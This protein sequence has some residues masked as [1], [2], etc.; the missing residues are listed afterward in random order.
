MRMGLSTR[1]TR[2]A[3]ALIVIALF[4]VWVAFVGVGDKSTNVTF[5]NDAGQELTVYPFGRNYPAQPGTLAAGES[6]KTSLLVSSENADTLVAR[7]EAYD[8]AGTMLFCHGYTYGE[9]RKLSGVVHLIRGK[10]D[11]K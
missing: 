1:A 11:C 10:L 8:T 2:Y 5:V 7:I 4:A 3:I 9:L 6:F